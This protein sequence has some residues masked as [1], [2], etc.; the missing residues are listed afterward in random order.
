MLGLGIIIIDILAVKVVFIFVKEFLN[1]KYF[2]G[3]IFNFWA[4]IKNI[5]GVGFLCWIL[6]LFFIII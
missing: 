1:I 6:G 3:E 2:F 5:F 4:V